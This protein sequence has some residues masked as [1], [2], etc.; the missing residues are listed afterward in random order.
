[1]IDNNSISAI[2]TEIEKV[3]LGKRDAIELTLAAFIARG[4]VLYEDIPGIGKTMLVKTIAKVLDCDF[5]RLQFTPDL[6]PSDVIGVNIYNPNINDFEFRKGPIFTDILLADEINRTTPR[7]QSA[8]L[9]AMSETYVSVD[10]STMPLSD[11]FFVLATQNPINFEG[12][13]PLPEAQ[14]DRFMIRLSLGYPN[15]QEELDLISSRP[16]QE[17]LD[18]IKP[19]HNITIITQL[20]SQLNDVKITESLMKYILRIV[21]AT[22][23]HNDIALGVSPRATIHFVTM[24]K[25]LALVRG[26]DFVIPSD[27][28]E[29]LVPVFGHRI[30]MKHQSMSVEDTLYSLLRTIEVPNF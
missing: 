6:L 12:T 13:Y 24:L 5:K 1:M 4:H 9:E 2:I 3:I 19:I 27:I 21:R 25:S 18:N 14:L 17:I 30:Q 20:R 28:E 16:R 8:L 23:T 10:G 22:R 15:F 26:R 7:T 11:D 29:L